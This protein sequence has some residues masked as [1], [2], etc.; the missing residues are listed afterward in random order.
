MYTLSHFHGNVQNHDS[1][2]QIFLLS[3]ASNAKYNYIYIAFAHS[4]CC[5]TNYRG[6]YRK[7][8]YT[9]HAR[10]RRIPLRPSE[11]RDRSKQLFATR[12]DTL[13][14]LVLSRS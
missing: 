1:W 10:E 2:N 6:T 9:K 14:S 12:M 4:I 8:D 7:S 13:F 5:A 11:F 3:I